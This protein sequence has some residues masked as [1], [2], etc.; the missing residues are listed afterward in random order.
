VA[1]VR[2][3]RRYS[4][5]QAEYWLPKIFRGWWTEDGVR[6]EGFNWCVRLQHLGHRETVNLGEADKARAAAEAMAVY[7]RLRADGW[8][9]VHAI[10][11]PEKQESQRPPAVWTVAAVLEA[12][13]ARSTIKPGTM[14]SYRDSLQTI[15]AGVAGIPSGRSL[16]SKALPAWRDRVGQ[17]RLDILNPVSIAEWRGEYVKHPNP[18]MAER[19]THSAASFIRNARAL[20]KC[21]GMPESPFKGVK[22]GKEGVSTITHLATRHRARP[23]CR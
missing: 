22:L 4:R 21:E 9:A 13:K 15:V 23:M 12:A 14:R 6:R 8:D 11:K 16:G 18:V 5:Y 17:E 1:K 3:S 10:Y 7:A 19:R 20:F 2:K